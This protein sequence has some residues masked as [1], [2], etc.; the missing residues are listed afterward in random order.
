MLLFVCPQEESL[1]YKDYSTVAPVFTD[2][3]DH[4][5]EFP[6]NDTLEDVDEAPLVEEK[7]LYHPPYASKYKATRSLQWLRGLHYFIY[8]LHH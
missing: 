5:E 1:A 6:Q 7:H 4:E 8:C 2:R 3:Q